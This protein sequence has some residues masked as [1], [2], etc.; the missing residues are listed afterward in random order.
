M[1]GTACDAAFISKQISQIEQLAVLT[2]TDHAD[3]GTIDNDLTR[4]LV[5]ADCKCR[6]HNDSP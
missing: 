4:I 1:V 2:P 5:S 6:K 3:L